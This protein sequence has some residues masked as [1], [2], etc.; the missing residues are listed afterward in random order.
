MSVLRSVRSVCM[1][2]RQAWIV[3]RLS[4]YTPAFVYATQEFANTGNHIR[5]SEER[6]TLTNRKILIVLISGYSEYFIPWRRI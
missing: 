6:I 5:L 2:K 3:F 1:K 4:H